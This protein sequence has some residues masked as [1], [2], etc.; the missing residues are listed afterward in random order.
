MSAEDDELIKQAR[1]HAWNWFSLH[2]TQRMQCVNY[3]L[4]ATAFLAAAYASL[5]EKHPGPGVCVA[6]AGA[7]IG[8][9]FNRL[10]FRTRQLVRAG[11]RVLEVAQERLAKR[12]DIES[13]RIIERVEHPTGGAASYTLVIGVVQ[14][15]AI[16]GFAA[17]AIYAAWLALCSH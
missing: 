13:I 4:V 14:W 6:L 5:L 9:W 11:E 1:E 17:A 16:L 15:T 12:V 7:W 2:A 8:F 3:F 10:D